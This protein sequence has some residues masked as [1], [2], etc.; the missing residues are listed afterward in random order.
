M[1]LFW[2]L[3]ALYAFILLGF[4]LMALLVKLSQFA[5]ITHGD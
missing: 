3:L 4:G 5:F 2:A 1:V